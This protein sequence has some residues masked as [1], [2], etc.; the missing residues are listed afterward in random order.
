MIILRNL[1]PRYFQT[2]FFRIGHRTIH[3]SQVD[4]M[5]K[6]EELGV[7]INKMYTRVVDSRL[8]TR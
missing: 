4:S 6:K 3:I 2:F 1:L 8:A 5:E 7:L